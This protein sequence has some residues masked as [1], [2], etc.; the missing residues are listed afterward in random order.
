MEES[1]SGYM[2]CRE[3]VRVERRKWSWNH[4]ILVDGPR[5]YHLLAREVRKANF[6]MANE[7]GG[8][9]SQNDG[10]RSLDSLHSITISTLLVP[11]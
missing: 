2:P 6:S 7:K 5:L 11:C 8:P 9:S 3:N 10:L 4:W 1:D